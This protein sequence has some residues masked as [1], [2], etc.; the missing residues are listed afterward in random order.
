[1]HARAHA[2][3]PP[4]PVP[5]GSVA[6]AAFGLLALVVHE[7]HGSVLQAAAAVF[8]RLTPL[9]LGASAATKRGGGGV[10]DRRS[11]AL[12][13]V[14]S[15]FRWEFWRC[16]AVYSCNAIGTAAVGQAFGTGQ[17]QA[18]H[19]MRMYTSPVCTYACAAYPV[20]V[21]HRLAWN[22]S[23]LCPCAPK[24]PCSREPSIQ[25]CMVA[26]LRHVCLRVSD[27][28]ESR[29][30]AVGAVLSLVSFAAVQCAA[31]IYHHLVRLLV[32]MR[33]KVMCRKHERQQ[34]CRP[35]L[36]ARHA[37][38]CP[39]NS[40][41]TAT[42]PPFLDALLL[43]LCTLPRFTSVK[44]SLKPQGSAP[45]CTHPAGHAAWWPPAGDSAA[46]GRP[47]AALP[48]HPTPVKDSQGETQDVP[49]PGLAQALRARL[50]QSTPGR[51]VLAT[52]SKPLPTRPPPPW[53]VGGLMVDCRSAAGWRR[54]K[55]H[56]ACS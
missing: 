17:T 38:L 50:L 16:R 34:G 27:R 4:L 33:S 13:F 51:T 26:L 28:A 1:M 11:T 36:P 14:R 45:Q 52:P 44:N 42:A 7:R 21:P 20:T 31:L 54:W 8:H 2:H 46:A 47:P 29:Q 30:L 39:H 24:I 3:R 25:P 53:C 49:P 56:T 10:L 41:P 9:L 55:L 19:S 40:S 22:P 5:A 37:A 23:P 35:V 12:D 6:E 18:E 32:H 15:L 48:L 43:G